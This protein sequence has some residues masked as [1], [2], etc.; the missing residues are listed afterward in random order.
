M[1]RPNAVDW[2][3]IVRDLRFRH[4]HRYKGASSGGLMVLPVAYRVS[5]RV[6]AGQFA[7]RF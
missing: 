3:A 7:T 4:L 2:N 6:A 1:T 5:L